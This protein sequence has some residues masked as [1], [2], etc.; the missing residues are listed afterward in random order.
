ME[1]TFKKFLQEEEDY[2]AADMKLSVE[3]KFPEWKVYYE[4]NIWGHHG[5]DHAGKEILVNQHF[6]WAG[7]HWFIPT[8]YSCGKG[9]VI[10][11]CMRVDARR[12]QNFM[13]KWKLSCKSDFYDGFTNEQQ[14]QME[15]ENPLCFHFHPMLKLNNKEMTVSRGCAICFNP[16][17]ADK[18]GYDLE[19]KRVVEHYHL[20][21]SYGWVI[22]RN[23]FPWTSKHHSEIKSLSLIMEQ[24][25]DRVPGE[26][27]VVQAP[28]DKVTFI[29]PISGKAFELTVQSI[30]QQILPE[31]SLLPKRWRYPTYFIS[32]NYTVS[33][34]WGKEIMIHDCAESDQPMENPEWNDKSNLGS[35][36]GVCCV[37]IIGG[38]SGPTAMILEND[39]EEKIHSVCSSLHFELVQD[40]VEWYI[41]YIV[42]QFSDAV[43]TLI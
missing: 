1:N 22:F 37:S 10:D 4:G 16:Y 25:P 11:F 15:I 34:E 18:N 38:N 27:F 40:N 14:M 36:Q 24:Q 6:D 21:K 23:A 20:D 26:H 43:F 29:H 28:G 7:Y 5:R 12:I 39:A 2:C 17:L 35:T 13:E 9:L 3:S 42:K 30:E 32:M 19:T 41:S 8:V 31:S 33:P